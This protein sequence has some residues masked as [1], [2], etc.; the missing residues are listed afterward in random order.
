MARLHAGRARLLGKEAQQNR[1]LVARRAQ[2]RRGGGRRNV[3]ARELDQELL[4][5]LERPVLGIQQSRQQVARRQERR[6][7][8]ERDG[9]LG[10]GLADADQAVEGRRVG[11]RLEP[12]DEIETAAEDV[13][14][15]QLQLR[16]AGKDALHRL[17][18]ERRVLQRLLV[19]LGRERRVARHQRLVQHV[20]LQIVRKQLAERAEQHQHL[21]RA[22]AV[23]VEQLEVEQ[24]LEAAAHPRIVASLGRARHGENPRLALNVRRIE[25]ADRARQ[26]GKQNRAR[27]DL[28]KELVPR[29]LCR[30]NQQVRHL[31]DRQ[32]VRLID[33]QQQLFLLLI[34]SLFLATSATVVVSWHRRW[35]RRWCATKWHLIIK[36]IA[37]VATLT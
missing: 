37:H 7:G 34:V 1:E 25:L 16:E 6:D 17:D 4:E 14:E 21:G 11:L 12:L 24:Q 13:E 19:P 27:V 32:L 22:L 3:E 26:L 10:V 29:S 15:L 30:R 35:R 5:A 36:Q 23:A 31:V 9:V 2:V 18:E 33:A 28:A 20:L 8:L